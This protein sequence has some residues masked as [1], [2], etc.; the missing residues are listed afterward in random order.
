MDAQHEALLNRYFAATHEFRF[1]IGI[2]L[3]EYAL[4][5]A[6]TVWRRDWFLKVLNELFFAYRVQFEEDLRSTNGESIQQEDS[7]V[8]NHKWAGC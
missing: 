1:A 7:P 4:F 5:V 6:Q 3:Q 8:D 2:S